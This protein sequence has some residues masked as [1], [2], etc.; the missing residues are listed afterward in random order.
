MVFTDDWWKSYYDLIEESERIIQNAGKE[1]EELKMGW[2][3]VYF[4]FN[5]A[6]LRKY[7]ENNNREALSEPVKHVYDTIKLYLENHAGTNVIVNDLPQK[8]DSTIL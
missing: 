2:N 5:I 1:R 8:I 7:L 3:P 4:N 6:E